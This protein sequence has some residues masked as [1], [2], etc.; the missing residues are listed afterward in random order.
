MMLLGTPLAMSESFQYA[1]TENKIRIKTEKK[2][3]KREIK[4]E[5]T[6]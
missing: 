4:S 2:K 6:E 5:K 1:K 3:K